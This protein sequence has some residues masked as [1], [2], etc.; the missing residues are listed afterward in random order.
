[1]ISQSGLCAQCI[2]G[3]QE[4]HRL[5]LAAPKLVR[6]P[7]RSLFNFAHPVC[8]SL[9]NL[10]GACKGRPSAHRFQRRPCPRFRFGRILDQ[11]GFF[12][13]EPQRYMPCPD[14]PC[15]RIGP[16]A[17]KDPPVLPDLRR[18]ARSGPPAGYRRSDH[19]AMSTTTRPWARP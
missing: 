17:I 7:Q 18:E 19:P 11:E 13:R 8:R 4:P 9:S 1:M 10:D 12:T 14:C 15:L 3:A 6:V 2:R 16:V 5:R